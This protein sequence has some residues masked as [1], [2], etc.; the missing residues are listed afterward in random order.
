MIFFIPNFREWGV[1]QQNHIMTCPIADS[2]SGSRPSV[3]VAGIGGMMRTPLVVLIVVLSLI[4]FGPPCWPGESE[5]VSGLPVEELTPSFL[6]LAVTGPHKGKEVC[7][8]CEFIGAPTIFAFFRQTGDE[9]ASVVK[10]LN[11][12]ARRNQDIRVVAV[13]IEGQDS[14][15]WLEKFAQENGIII[16]LTVLRNGKD[17]VA[18]KV[19]KLN[20]SVSNTILMSVKRKVAA[21]LVNVNAENF[22]ML[23]NTV[24]KMLHQS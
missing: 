9:M 18:G 15:P 16:P 23:T 6:V 19:Y 12:L 8:V 3:Q 20:A 7:Y 4:T 21:N 5:A 14:Q 2:V 17:D 22:K 11:E 13:V 10:E 1:F 24:S